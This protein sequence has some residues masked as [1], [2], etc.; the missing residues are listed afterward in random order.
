MRLLQGRVFFTFLNVSLM[1]GLVRCSG[2]VTNWPV[3]RS[4]SVLNWQNEKLISK[5]I[6]T[7]SLLN[8]R[9]NGQTSRLNFNADVQFAG[10]VFN[11]S[12]NRYEMMVDWGMELSESTLEWD[13][14]SQLVQL[15][16]TVKL[17]DQLVQKTLQG[18]FQSHSFILFESANYPANHLLIM[19][20]EVKALGVS[21]CFDACRSLITDIYLRVS[22]Q[23]VLRKQVVNALHV[24]GLRRALP[25]RDRMQ[26][27]VPM[28]A[29]SSLVLRG[30]IS[31]AG[32][33]ASLPISEVSQMVEKDPAKPVTLA[34]LW[35][36]SKKPKN[37]PGNQTNPVEQICQDLQIESA[38]FP[39]SRLGVKYPGQAMGYYGDP[40]AG[41]L[42]QGT[43]VEGEGEGFK[44][45][46]AEQ[47]EYKYS[48]GAGIML[49]WIE[50]VGKIYFQR[51][52]ELMSIGDIAK[53]NG[54]KFAPHLSHQNGL[55]VDVSLPRKQGAMD[56]ERS[57]EMLKA[58]FQTGLVHRIGTVQ[59]NKNAL[60][61]LAKQKNEFNDNQE[62]FKNLVDWEGHETHFHFRLKCTAHN[63]QQCRVDASVI[64]KVGCP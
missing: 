52:Q 38:L 26:S 24:E 58:A 49:K 47:P 63:Q 34:D 14:E 22:E 10:D 60:C 32:E 56:V 11:V 43:A 17:K 33:F 50:V 31:L 40:I 57:W 28:S 46:R 41:S 6:P 48:F 15:H 51:T 21:R 19:Y 20:D 30:P 64:N 9:D 37:K 4:Q 42:V 45:R 27:N 2:Q 25:E 5:S 62:L 8:T 7:Q 23:T 12:T 35:M 54:G 55:D 13:R 1:I 36:Q 59:A 18:A 53:E 39:C 61:K 29:S 44:S 3:N 16:I